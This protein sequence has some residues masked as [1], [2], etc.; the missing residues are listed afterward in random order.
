MPTAA[1]PR[2][3]IVSEEGYAQYGG[4]DKIIDVSSSFLSDGG[5][6]GDYAQRLYKKGGSQL[7]AVEKNDGWIQFL[8]LVPTAE[9]G[10]KYSNPLIFEGLLSIEQVTHTIDFDSVTAM[11]EI[12]GSIE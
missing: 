9:P 10:Q 12:S 2:A 3:E 11:T 7:Q 5:K 6:A 1:A 8:K 4:S